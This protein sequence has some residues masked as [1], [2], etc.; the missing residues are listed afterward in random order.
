MEDLENEEKEAAKEGY[1]LVLG[2]L[3][4]EIQVSN[5]GQRLAFV[6][7]FYSPW[8]PASATW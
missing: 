3:T 8:Q 7:Q 2:H 5:H 6:H 1:D 4:I